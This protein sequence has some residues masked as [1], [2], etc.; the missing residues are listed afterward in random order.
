MRTVTLQFNFRATPDINWSVKTELLVDEA[1]DP[2]A[3]GYNA[4]AFIMQFQKG[5]TEGLVDNT[6]D[7]NESDGD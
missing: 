2:I 7:D 5:M 6:P 4:A 1:D 3:A